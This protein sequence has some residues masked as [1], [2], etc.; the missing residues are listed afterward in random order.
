MLRLEIT[1]RLHPRSSSA[2]LRS[3]ETKLIA[4]IQSYHHLHSVEISPKT[5]HS[6]IFTNVLIALLTRPYLRQLIINSA[7]VDEDGIST[8]VTFGNLEQLE[9]QDPSRAILNVLPSWLSS[10]SNR[11]TELHLKVRLSAP[12]PGNSNI[13]IALVRREIVDLSRQPSSGRSFHIY[14][15]VF[16]RSLWGFRIPSPMMMYLHSWANYLT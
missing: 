11:L 10:L 3:L 7:C 9:L 13:L 16:V 4:A 14:G 15:T 5:D 8:L 1:G 6:H 2:A 12:S